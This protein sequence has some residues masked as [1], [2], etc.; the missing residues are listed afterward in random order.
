MTKECNDCNEK[1]IIKANKLDESLKCLQVIIQNPS[2]DRF[3]ATTIVL[4]L[5]R[6]FLRSLS[7]FTSRLLMSSNEF[8]FPAKNLLA[9][10]EDETTSSLPASETSFALLSSSPSSVSTVA[11]ESA[12]SIGS[13]LATALSLSKVSSS[14]FY[15]KR[16]TVFRKAY[17]IRNRILSVVGYDTV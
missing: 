11:P 6:R 2:S 14:T 12:M 9:L 4:F 13:D 7:L 3:L 10:G 5:T 16:T 8:E 1:V 15:R 17:Y